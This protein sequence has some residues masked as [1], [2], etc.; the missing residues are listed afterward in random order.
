M[1]IAY[2][3][4]YGRK[5]ELREHLSVAGRVLADDADEFRARIRALGRNWSVPLARTSAS[6]NARAKSGTGPAPVRAWRLTLQDLL[7]G[8]NQSVF[9]ATS[10]PDGSA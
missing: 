10:V 6:V 5:A 3:L 9:T 1:L 4:C 7:E 8:S 2:L